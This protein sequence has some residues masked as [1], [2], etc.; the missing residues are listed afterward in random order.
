M[1]ATSAPPATRRAR[2]TR[3]LLWCICAMLLLA[4]FGLYTAPGFVVM[5]ADQLW[6]CF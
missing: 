6:S 2:I 1:R 3:L 5:V 4:V